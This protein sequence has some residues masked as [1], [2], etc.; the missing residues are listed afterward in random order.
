MVCFLY[1][2]KHSFEQR[3]TLCICDHASSLGQR[4]PHREENPASTKKRKQAGEN[5]RLLLF[6]GET[7]NDAVGRY[8]FK[9]QLTDILEKSCGND[10]RTREYSPG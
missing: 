9:V 2:S 4:N 8:F 6:F 7:S 1:V 3:K 5:T 10:N